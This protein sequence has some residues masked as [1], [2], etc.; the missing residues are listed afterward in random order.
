MTI[1]EHSSQHIEISYN[2]ENR[3]KSKQELRIL[4]RVYDAGGQEL[5]SAIYMGEFPAG[6]SRRYSKVFTGLSRALSEGEIPGKADVRIY[7]RRVF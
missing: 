6:S 4:A 1:D 7:P 2:V 3:L 5:A